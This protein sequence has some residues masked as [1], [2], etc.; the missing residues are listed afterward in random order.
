MMCILGISEEDSRQEEK[1]D[2]EVTSHDV[3][4]QYLD[5]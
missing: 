2:D 4:S 5:R 3:I 1:V